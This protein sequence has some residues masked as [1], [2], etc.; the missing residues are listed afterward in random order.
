ME[1]MTSNETVNP[2]TLSLS[3]AVPTHKVI[4]LFCH[5]L[6]PRITTDSN[7]ANCYN[8]RDHWV[9]TDT[10]KTVRQNKLS[11]Y[12]LVISVVCYKERKMTYM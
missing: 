1:G 10:L 11:F 4:I 9:S 2:R 7:S 8:N 12:Q 6:Q 3:F 5:T